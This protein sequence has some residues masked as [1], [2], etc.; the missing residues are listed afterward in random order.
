LYHPSE[1]LEERG[2]WLEPQETRSV[3][4]DV[5]QQ[6]QDLLQN[7]GVVPVLDEDA[8]QRVQQPASVQF[9]HRTNKNVDLAVSPYGR[10]VPSGSQEG[11]AYLLD[12]RGGAVSGKVGESPAGIHAH[13][14]GGAVRAQDPDDRCRH[15]QSL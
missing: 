4:G 8:L 6:P 14:I 12:G 1:S 2:V 13:D 10:L 11:R 3:R 7:I 9:L 5:G 15:A